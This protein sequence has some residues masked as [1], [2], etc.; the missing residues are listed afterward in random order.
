MNKIDLINDE[1]RSK[2]D[3]STQLDVL[4]WL[5]IW[6]GSQAYFDGERKFGYG[7]Y[8]YDGRW[9]KIVSNLIEQYQLTTESTL[10]DVGCAKGYLVKDF[11]E[12]EKVGEAIG[13]DIS[14]YALLNGRRDCVTQNL[15]CAN[16]SNLPFKDKAFEVVFCKDS[17]HNLLSKEELV[18]ALREIQRVGQK[19]WVRVGAF[20]NN[21]Q[22]LVLDEWA[23]FATCYFHV[24][25]WLELFREAGFDG[26]FDWF[27]PCYKI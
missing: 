2:R 18:L 26:D 1:P 23:T 24:D 5:S 16:A 12:N 17:L 22:K 14:L 19:S 15:I 9:K 6:E 20:K 27:H 8:A 10:L 11:C 7:G 25:E 3:A 4:E 13:V 21:E